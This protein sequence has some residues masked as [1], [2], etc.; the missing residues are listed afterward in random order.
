[1]T[2]EP[3]FVPSNSAYITINTDI[4]MNIRLVDCVGYVIPSSKGY[5]NEDGSP[6]LVSTPWKT[7]PIPFEEA[8]LLGTKKVIENH[9]HIGT[10]FFRGRNSCERYLWGCR[11]DI[12]RTETERYEEN[13]L[14]SSVSAF[15]LH[16]F[17]RV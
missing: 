2:V 16:G 9:S 5:L 11:F 17:G 7:D 14:C 15:G 1:M 8:A 12:C 13:I 6:R 10:H 4:N 3:K